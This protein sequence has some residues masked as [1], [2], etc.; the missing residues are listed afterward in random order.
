M[1]GDGRNR[2]AAVA[3]AAVVAVLG[4]AFVA[5]QASAAVQAQARG[6]D[7]TTVK[8]AGLGNVATGW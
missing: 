1:R 2:R 3:I 8:V 4:G 6:F 5:S 7:G